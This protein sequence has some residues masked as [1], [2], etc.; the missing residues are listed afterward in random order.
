MRPC[1]EQSRHP[2]LSPPRTRLE[3]SVLDMAAEAPSLDEAVSVILRAIGRR[4]TTP[5]GLGPAK[6]SAQWALVRAFLLAC[7][8]GR[9]RQV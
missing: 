3:D 2:V 5:R 1:S 6:G 4:L 8:H 7:D 9:R